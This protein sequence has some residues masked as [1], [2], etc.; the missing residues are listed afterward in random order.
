MRQQRGDI[1]LSTLV[2][3]AM[4]IGYIMVGMKIA[5]MY[6]D[7]LTV[8]KC[9]KTVASS[10]DGQRATVDQLK[11]KLRDQLN[12]NGLRETIPFDALKV[13]QKGNTRYLAL[14]FS[15][16]EVVFSDFS[17]TGKFDLETEILANDA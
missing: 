16:S 12:I 17:V 2:F 4:F 1:S 7:K 14:S 8:E 11:A 9:L 10:K 5:P 13:T 6:W 15:M 3:V